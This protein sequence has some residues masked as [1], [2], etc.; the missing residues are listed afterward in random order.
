M[1]RLKSLLTS[2]E[3]N[4]KCTT[5]RLENQPIGSNRK[6][7]EPIGGIQREQWIGLNRRDHEPVEGTMN[8]FKGLLTKI[9]RMNT[10][11]WTGWRHNQP[12]EKVKGTMNRFKEPPIGL[13]PTWQIFPKITKTLAKAPKLTETIWNDIERVYKSFYK[14]K[15]K[16]PRVY[17]GMEQHKS[18]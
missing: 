8:R 7:H 9:T 16:Y 2:Q 6:N 10:A 12:V 4:T 18:I 1:N 15:L 14:P 11:Q 3:D 17:K 5:N 13:N